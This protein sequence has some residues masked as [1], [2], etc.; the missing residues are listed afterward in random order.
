MEWLKHLVIR[1]Y[2]KGI[3]V[4]RLIQGKYY[5]KYDNGLLSYEFNYIDNQK[6]GTQYSWYKNGDI[7]YLDEYLNGERHG[8]SIIYDPVN[9]IYI[10]SIWNRGIADT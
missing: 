4:N 8:I 1:N 2:G 10:T 6:H 5:T 9:N 3:V 7:H